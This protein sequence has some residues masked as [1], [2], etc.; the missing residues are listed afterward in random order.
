[1]SELSLPQ[2]VFCA[3]VSYCLAT[4][5]VIRRYPAFGCA[6]LVAAYVP[7]NIRTGDVAAVRNTDGELKWRQD[8]SRSARLR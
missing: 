4:E 7:E 3:L 2:A 8:C 6:S 1:M 5:M